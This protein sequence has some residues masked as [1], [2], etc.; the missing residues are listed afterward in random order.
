M[1]YLIERTTLAFSR[2]TRHCPDGKADINITNEVRSYIHGN[3]NSD[4][5][6]CH[7][8]EM[9]LKCTSMKHNNSGG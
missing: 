4:L 3:V 9:N 7:R 2:Y 6:P 1:C 8:A 5:P